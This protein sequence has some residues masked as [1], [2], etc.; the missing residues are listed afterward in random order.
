SGRPESTIQL[1]EAYAKANLLWRDDADPIVYSSTLALDLSMVEPSLA[2]P[3]R[4]QDRVPL[5]Q[6]KEAWHKALP[7]LLGGSASS[8]GKVKTTYRGEEFELTHGDVAIAA[9]TSCTNTSI[10]SVMI[11]AG[12]LAKKAAERGL[13]AKPWVKTSLAPGSR[14]VTDYLE[15]AGLMKALEQVGFYTVGYG[16]TTC[17]GNSGPLP[18]EIREAVEKWGLVVNAVLSG[19]RNFEGRVSPHTRGNYLM[20]P[21][22][23]VAYA[24]AGNGD[25][26][27]ATEPLGIGKDGTP[28]FL[29][30]VW[31]RSQEIADTVAKAV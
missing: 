24:L 26:D 28:V 2:R 21:M 31:P 15:R 5:S 1:V 18:D 22:L 9:I 12:L 25:L 23:V 6:M 20:S 30:D 19:N 3:K 4:P 13:V 10:P 16:C 11:G 29:G 7:E 17:I 14:V 27:L 8:F